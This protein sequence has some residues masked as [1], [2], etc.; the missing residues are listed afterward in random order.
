MLYFQ[1]FSQSLLTEECPVKNKA[2]VWKDELGVRG[3]WG[4]HSQ[5]RLKFKYKT[6]H[7][8]FCMFT[9]AIIYCSYTI[10]VLII[11]DSHIFW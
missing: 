7:N 1:E 3:R 8:L 2:D 11:F 9:E 10:V 5:S 6:K 4:L